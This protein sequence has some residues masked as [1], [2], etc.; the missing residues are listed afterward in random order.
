M[1]VG[2]EGPSLRWPI[3]TGSP[4]EVEEQK[5]ALRRRVPQ[6]AGAVSDGAIQDDREFPGKG[7]E[8]LRGGG[9]PGSTWC[10]PGMW[11]TSNSARVRTSNST[12]F[13]RWG[14]AS[15]GQFHGAQ[16]PNTGE[17]L[18]DQRLHPLQSVL[19]RLTCGDIQMLRSL[20]LPFLQTP[21]RPGASSCVMRIGRDGACHRPKRT[22]PS[23]R[24]AGYGMEFRHSRR[25][26]WRQTSRP[27]SRSRTADALFIDHVLPSSWPHRTRRTLAVITPAIC[28]RIG[29]RAANWT[30]VCCPDGFQAGT[31]RGEGTAGVHRRLALLDSG[32]VDAVHSRHSITSTRRSGSPRWRRVSM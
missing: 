16:V 32:C 7:G 21:R 27:V 24:A 9:F 22:P 15:H 11:L 12:G 10:A 26:V 20:R 29:C 17:S 19:S 18:T 3:G 13:G 23:M 4:L 28:W 30:A 1:S 8:R 5:P 2:L 25:R 6:S 31:L 14:S